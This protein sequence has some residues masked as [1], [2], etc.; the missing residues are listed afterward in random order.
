[1]KNIKKP[2]ICDE[3]ISQYSTFRVLTLDCEVIYYNS[4]ARRYY[5]IRIV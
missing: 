1:M 3:K 5:K 2:A 4:G